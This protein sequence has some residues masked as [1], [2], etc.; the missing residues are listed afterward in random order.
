VFAQ[1]GRLALVGVNLKSLNR[2][3]NYALA[4][5]G[6]GQALIDALK[7]IAETQGIPQI[8]KLP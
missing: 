8:S 1:K 4:G 3:G 6:S 2:A 7:K 5:S